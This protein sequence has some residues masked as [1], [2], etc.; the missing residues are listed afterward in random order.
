MKI[1]LRS[2]STTAL[3]LWEDSL[4]SPFHLR[5]SY[6]SWSL[7]QPEFLA[8]SSS[9]SLTCSLLSFASLSFPPNSFRKTPSSDRCKNLPLLVPPTAQLEWLKR[10]QALIP[11]AEARAPPSNPYPCQRSA[12]FPVHLSDC[13]KLPYSPYHLDN[14]SHTRV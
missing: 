2:N 9:Y 8:W 12:P 7:L 3:N 4:I 6:P 11:A 1:L 5:L 14:P 13:S 10:L